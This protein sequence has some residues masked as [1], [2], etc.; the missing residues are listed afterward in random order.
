MARKRTSKRPSPGL[1]GDYTDSCIICLQGCDTGLGFRG[2]GEWVVAGLMALGIRDFDEAAA[3]VSLATGTEP[4]MV[5]D[6][7]I[8]VGVRCCES[9]V[10]QSGTGFP[11]GLAV[12]GGELP[13]VEPTR[14]YR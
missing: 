4:G 9:C 5:P 6:G 10:A 1:R 8:T 12:R 14:T 2:E 7:V 13:C 3:V 11:L